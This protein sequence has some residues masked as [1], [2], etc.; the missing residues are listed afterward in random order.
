ML[1]G[2][3]VQAGRSKPSYTVIS[4]ANY[5]VSGIVPPSFPITVML[6]RIRDV[7]E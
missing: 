2:L 5:R 1:S 3:Q 7:Q 6:A 4:T